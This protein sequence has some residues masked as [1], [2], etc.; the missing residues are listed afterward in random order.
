MS[1]NTTQ[2][3]LLT[4]DQ[5]TRAHQMMAANPGLM[6]TTPRQ[7]MTPHFMADWTTPDEVSVRAHH[8]DLRTLLDILA[9]DYGLRE[10]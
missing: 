2:T 4:L 10:P 9:R 5:V 8:W 6:I 1:R 3:R 7:N